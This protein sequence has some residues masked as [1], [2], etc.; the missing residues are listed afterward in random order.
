MD[1]F[2]L[3][4]PGADASFYTDGWRC[5]IVWREKSR[6]HGSGSMGGTI[7]NN[8]QCVKRAA[9]SLEGAP[10]FLSAL[11]ARG[12]Q[13][14]AAQIESAATGTGAAAQPPVRSPRREEPR[15]RPAPRRAER[16]ERQVADEPAQAVWLSAL[17]GDAAFETARDKRSKTWYELGS[18]VV[19][20]ESLLLKTPAAKGKSEWVLKRTWPDDAGRKAE[21]VVAGSF[22]GVARH[23]VD[24]GIQAQGVEQ[25]LSA[26]SGVEHPELV[27][28]AKAW[29]A[30]GSTH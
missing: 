17:E 10:Y 12:H 18:P 28:A 14:L 27:E 25:M 2:E 3:N 22:K 4:W 7:D 23:L 30:K 8:Q 11:R 9:E 15:E 24:A 6:R 1:R 13:R 5:R 29:R 16:R 26:L 19:P 20:G 21:F